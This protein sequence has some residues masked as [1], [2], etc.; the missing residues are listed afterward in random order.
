M[1][2]LSRC[3][4]LHSAR[5][6]GHEVAVCERVWAVYLFCFVS[7]LDKKSGLEYL[8]DGT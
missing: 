5:H 3:S 4:G 1:K 6:K 2:F 8:L 7:M